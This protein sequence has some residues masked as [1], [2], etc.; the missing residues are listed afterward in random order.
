MVS[1]E[2]AAAAAASPD[3]KLHSV[4]ARR[5]AL[6]RAGFRPV[7]VYTVAGS[8]RARHTASV[9]K[10]PFGMGWQDA[11]RRDPPAA[12]A[13]PPNRDTSNTGILCDGLRAID[14]DIDDPKAAPRCVEIARVMFGNSP[15]RYRDNSARRLLVYRA[16][17]GEP[18]KRK[19]EGA[20]GKI[21]A[22]GYGQQF[23]AFGDH[24]SGADLQW[25]GDAP[26]SVSRD[27]LTAVTEDQITLFFEAVSPII[28]SKNPPK[29][30]RGKKKRADRVVQ[31]ELLRRIV[32][33]E[34]FHA[35]GVSLAGYFASRSVPVEAAIATILAAFDA[36]PV[37]SRDARWQER[38]DDAERCVRD[39]YDKEEEKRRPQGA[40]GVVIPRGF[41]LNERGLSYHP[42]PKNGDPA[43]VIWV[44][45]P[46]EVV[47]RTSDDT[48]F[49]HGVLVQWTDH[50]H[51]PHSW[52]MPRCKAHADG[53]EIAIEFESGGLTCGTSRAQHESLKN[54]FGAVRI[55]RHVRCVDRAGW[56]GALYV[57]PHGRVFG[58]DPG[59]IVLQTERAVA[60]SAY[61]ERGTLG[62]WQDNIA[63]YGVGNDLLALSISAAFAAPL[64]DVLGEMSGG[65]HLHGTSQSGKTTLLRS[66]MTVFGPGDDKHLRTWRG[67]SNGFEAAAAQHN[68]ALLVLD[69]M[70]Q[71]AARELDQTIY[72][73]ANNSGKARANRVGG[74][75]ALA[76]WRGLYLSSGE[77]TVEAKLAEAG[78]RVRAG[79]NV[80]M[81]GLPADAGAGLGVF[82][83]LHGFASGAALAEHLRAAASKCCG[84]A[85]PAYLDQL[86]R[87]RAADPGALVSTLRG[88]RD[89]FLRRHLARDADGQVHS[90]ATRFALIGAAGELATVYGV[91]GWPEGEAL[92]AAGWCIDHWLAVRGGTGAAEDMQAIEAVRGFVAAHGASRFEL[93]NGEAPGTERVVNRAGWKRTTDGMLE[94]LIEPSIWRAEICRGLDATRSALALEKAGFLVR[95]SGA[96]PT[97]LQRI[98]GYGPVRVYAV[99]GAIL[100]GG[101]DQ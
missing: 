25:D 6:W 42:P 45:G 97:S 69:E 32:A 36:V 56:H 44:C 81:I 20:A 82:Q 50:D 55:E 28:G 91:T 61:A 80:R 84:T 65:V 16:A 94:Y 27:G 59:S 47:A 70:L 40:A 5:E 100:G 63:R 37:A 67:T 89:A 54:F 92:R 85:G 30:E 1:V 11:A 77:I 2:F 76:F 13:N 86:A 71:A 72:M 19:I 41:E 88:L 73:L 4:A 57:Q 51:A 17:A 75:R 23:V 95:G 66:A 12:V 34:D 9:G 24:E 15:M 8:R 96:R 98:V 60:A 38:R 83:K 26:G 79:Q 74:A 78:L 46:F 87:A 90:V 18:K 58:G 43:P 99:R 39:I 68:D 21:E 48:H 62:E 31:T 29:K 101:D 35:S 33:G 14:V 64:L 49:N 22:L 7:A 3:D 52:A 53:N 10:R 93:L